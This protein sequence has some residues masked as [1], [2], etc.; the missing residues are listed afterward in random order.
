MTGYVVTGIICLLV[1]SVVGTVT[2]ALCAASRESEEQRDRV[3]SCDG[4]FGA[5]FGD[6]GDC[7]QQREGVN[8]NDR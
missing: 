8:R 7:P 2:M 6:C 5:S 4:C 1:G 3:G